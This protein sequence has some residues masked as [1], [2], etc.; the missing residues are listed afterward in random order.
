M[1][2]PGTLAKLITWCSFH[3]QSFHMY[4]SFPEI[5]LSMWV[6]R[7]PHPLHHAGPSPHGAALSCGP[8]LL[9]ELHQG[10]WRLGSVRTPTVRQCE[11]LP[12]HPGSWAKF[13]LLHMRSVSENRF[14]KCNC[15][16]LSGWSLSDSNKTLRWLMKCIWETEILF[17]MQGREVGLCLISI[18]LCNQLFS[19]S[20]ILLKL[21]LTLGHIGFNSEP[22]IWYKD[23]HLH[24][25]SSSYWEHFTFFFTEN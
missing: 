14:D 23:P 10:L 9:T 18:Y 4:P 11:P 8:A 15:L 16:P 7:H 22:P 6:G 19:V 3:W 12:V 2:A 1:K 25:L 21:I 13:S 5:T 17:L 20:K 24:L